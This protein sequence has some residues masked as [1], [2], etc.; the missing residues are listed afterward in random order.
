MFEVKINADKVTNKIKN[1]FKTAVVRSIN[2]TMTTLKKE[3]REGLKKDIGLKV[4]TMKPRARVA[5]KAKKKFPSSLFTLRPIGIPL[6]WFGAKKVKVR[7]PN[8][9]RGPKWR[10]GAR[11]SK[12]VVKGIAP[13]GFITQVGKGRHTG[14]FKRRRNTRLPIDEMYVKREVVE[15]ASRQYKPLTKR[16]MDLLKE[17]MKKNLESAKKKLE[18]G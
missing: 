7:V 2:Q 17:A 6:Y 13:G 4:K 1:S 9:R 10:Y 15:S 8:A 16:A 5:K 3:S 11:L 12:G 18:G 14:V